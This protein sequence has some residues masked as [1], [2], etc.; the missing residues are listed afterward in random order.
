M[1]GKTVRMVLFRGGLEDDQRYAHATLASSGEGGS[2]W[3][4]F[5]IDV[6]DP[7][8]RLM[9]T[10]SDDLAVVWNTSGSAR[11][12]KQPTRRSDCSFRCAMAISDFS[13]H[14]RQDTT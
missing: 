6:S 9:V 12:I 5:D 7:L 13:M 3:V 14:A 4:K 10:I 1:G 2:P 8:F 11:H